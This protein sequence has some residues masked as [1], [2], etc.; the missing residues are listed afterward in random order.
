MPEDD[1]MMSEFQFTKEQV[2]ILK[3]HSSICRKSSTAV[4]EGINVEDEAVAEE[5]QLCLKYA[6]L[7]AGDDIQL[8][9]LFIKGRNKIGTLLKQLLDLVTKKTVWINP[10]KP[11]LPFD[12]IQRS[13]YEP[14]Q[15]MLKYRFLD[16]V[17]KTQ[18]RLILL[19]D[20]PGM[21]KSTELTKLELDMRK[22]SSVESP[23]IIIRI[24]LKQCTQAL[25]DISNSE[26]ITIYDFI[27]TFADFI[28]IKDL[29]SFNYDNI[30]VFNSIGRARERRSQ[31][32]QDNDK[33]TAGVIG[34]C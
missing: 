2:E 1:D 20:G 6:I 22:T 28:P 25:L 27:E 13:L 9:T 14:E 17:L 10:S 3:S 34:E 23:R 26:T 8:E 30:P 15:I 7:F 29:D 16:A 4:Y 18:K 19:A 5:A 24:N 31:T 32:Y 12:Y 11:N 21:G 33:V